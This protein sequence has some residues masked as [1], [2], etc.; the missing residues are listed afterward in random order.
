MTESEFKNVFGGFNDFPP[1]W[2]EID[3]NEFG[4]KMNHYSFIKSEYRQMHLKG[5]DYIPALQ[6]TL[7]FFH[8]NTG[9][10]VSKE[11]IKEKGKYNY[12]QISRFFAFGCDHD[13]QEIPWNRE[14][15][16]PQYK[17]LHA[18]KCSKCG[19][20]KSVDSSD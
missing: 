12:K 18:M 2:R 10:A 9:I 14:Q 1:Q 11:S 6:A 5:N 3:P 20:L 8:D 15:F 16:G 7:F 4:Q 19:M 13:Y 17:G